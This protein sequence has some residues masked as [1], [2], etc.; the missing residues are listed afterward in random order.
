[1]SVIHNVKETTPAALTLIEG[2]TAIGERVAAFKTYMATGMQEAH[3]LACSIL[4]HVGKHSDVRLV[5]TLLDACGDMTRKNALKAWFEAHGPIAFTEKGEIKFQPATTLA[6]A[7]AM[8]NPFWKF[9]PEAEYVPMDVA[10]A[11][12]SLIKKLE[13]DG[14]KTGRNHGSMVAKLLAVRPGDDTAREVA[15]ATVAAAVETATTEAPAPVEAPV[16]AP[17]AS[18]RRRQRVA[19]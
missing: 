9:K 15:N 16:V 14:K 7:K 13:T 1:M 5:T 19:A 11:I 18:A 2:A 10:K 8:G 17:A 3:L 4:A 6:L 12:D